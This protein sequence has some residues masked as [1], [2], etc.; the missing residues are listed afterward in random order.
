MTDG[1]TV[2]IIAVH[3]KVGRAIGR[4]KRID[5]FR[6]VLY[7]RKP[8]Q[9]LPDLL[10]YGAKHNVQRVVLH[11]QK[12][13]A[14]AAG[15]RA[16]P[17]D[18]P[19]GQGAKRNDSRHADGNA[20]YG[21]QGAHPAM[22]QVFQNHDTGSILPLSR[23]TDPV[24]LYVGTAQT[25]KSEARVGPLAG[26]SYNACTLNQ[27]DRLDSGDQLMTATEQTFPKL[28]PLDVHPFV[29][30]GRQS[31]LLR[32][33][34]QLCEEAVVVPQPLHL[35]LPLC[36][37]TREDAGALSASLAIRHGI[38]IPPQA[39]D[40]LLAAL[41]RTCLLDNVT[42]V[43]AQERALTQYRAAPFRPAANAG[44]SYP[45]DTQ[46][47]RELA[48][49]IPGRARY[50]ASSQEL[51]TNSACCL[52]PIRGLISPHIDY[53]RGG[54]V[55]A[56]V[57]GQARDAVREADLVFILGTDHYGSAGTITFTRQHYATPYGVL[58]T[59]GDVVDALAEALGKEAAF[60][61]E[62]HH[63]TEHS[64]ELAAIWLHHVRD[65]RPCE[66]VPVLCGSFRQCIQEQHERKR[67][68]GH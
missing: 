43:Q 41:D 64:I 20:K 17:G 40:Q 21:Q 68:S 65:G 66:M 50:E 10:V 56:Q 55:Y 54:P 35:V 59:A 5:H 48:G 8:G 27:A 7:V 19:V 32:D 15:Q 29:Q 49:R 51:S 61:E 36:D 16:V 44:Q 34:L 26:T 58:P 24:G 28:R 14:A 25:S 9:G 33:P 1:K 12:I 22:Q 67:G 38:R 47:V 39:I 23:R 45:A 6:D 3:D 57:W 62:L 42:Y 13:G 4:G 46:A 60:A 63:R 2:R 11:D 18:K 30:N 52:P 37:G 31:F 53:A